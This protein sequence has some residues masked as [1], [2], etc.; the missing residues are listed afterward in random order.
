[1][2]IVVDVA[3]KPRRPAPLST[4]L[5]LQLFLKDVLE[6]GPRLGRC[7]T[8]SAASSDMSVPVA[9]CTTFSLLDHDDAELAAGL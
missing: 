4:L 7:A 1:M 5:G 6:A 8:A 2:V 3:K 9:F